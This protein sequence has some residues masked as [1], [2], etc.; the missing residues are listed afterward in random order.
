MT[1][2]KPFLTLGALSVLLAACAGGGNGAAPAPAP[3]AFSIS[4]PAEIAVS[5][6]GA[7][8]FDIGVTLGGDFSGSSVLLEH[9]DLPL[10]YAVLYGGIPLKDADLGLSASGGVTLQLTAEI[11]AEA[12]NAFFEITGQ[13]LDDRGSTR[14]QPRNQKAIRI[15]LD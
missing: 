11:G 3:G 9:N 12:D 2:P 5:E 4:A 10:G 1:K 8:D 15:T 13:G 14:N 6:G 7:T